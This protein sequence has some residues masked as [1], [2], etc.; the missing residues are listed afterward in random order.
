MAQSVKD[1]LKLRRRNQ[2]S[3]RAGEGISGTALAPGTVSASDREGLTETYGS[4]SAPKVLARRAAFDNQLPP[5]STLVNRMGRIQ[6]KYIMVY[7]IY[8]AL[9]LK[10]E[11]K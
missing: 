1:Q 7:S 4:A 5:C 3:E 8:L 10:R 6:M 11:K 9:A 2:T